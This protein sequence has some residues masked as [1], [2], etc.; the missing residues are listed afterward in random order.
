MS[1]GRTTRSGRRY[2]EFWQDLGNIK[3]V[4]IKLSCPLLDNLL[5]QA[6]EREAQPVDDPLEN[7][8]TDLPSQ[9]TLDPNLAP[10]V[11]KRAV[12]EDEDAEE[13]AKGHN[14]HRHSKRWKPIQTCQTVSSSLN[15]AQL[16]AASGGSQ[17]AWDYVEWDGTN[18]L[19][20][21]DEAGQI[22][23]VGLKN[24]RDPSYNEDMEKLADPLE[25]AQTMK[26]K[27]KREDL[28]HL[29]G[30]GFAAAATGWSMG[31]GQDR[32]THSA[33]KHE[34]VTQNLIQEP[35]M[36]RLASTQD[37]G[38][39]CW[40]FRNYELH[41]ESMGQ[42][43]SSIEGF[44]PNFDRSHMCAITAVGQFKSS[45]GGHLV[46]PDLKVIIEF[47]S[48][49]TFLLPSAVLQHGNTQI[50]EGET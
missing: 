27:L 41:K 19:L 2:V 29:R 37:A 49:C 45:E 22:F 15:V 4:T 47:P 9:S 38:F 25:G 36:W 8:D 6:L 12:P 13:P 23:M 43:R 28:N 7:F 46:L 3:I 31:G 48:G 20:L 35:C 10:P 32:V 26:L 39:A 17:P 30:E 1:N 44:K 5:Q 16:P 21:V 34:E 24:I 14:T 11:K 42:L 33:G 18:T 50:Q 40:L